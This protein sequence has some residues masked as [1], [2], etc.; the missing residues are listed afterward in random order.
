MNKLIQTLCVI[1]IIASL[2]YSAS[3]ALSFNDDFDRPDDIW[4]GNGWSSWGGNVSLRTGRLYAG[5]SSAGGCGIM[6]DDLP[7]PLNAPMTFDFDFAVMADNPGIWVIQINTTNPLMTNFDDEPRLLALMQHEGEGGVRR[8]VGA[9]LS[10]GWWHSSNARSWDDGETVHVSG[11]VFSDLSVEVAVDYLDG[12]PMAVY[13]IPG[14]GLNPTTIDQ[15]LLF[16]IGTNNGAGYFDNLVVTPE[17]ATLSLLAIGGLAMLRRRKRLRNKKPRTGTAS[18]ASISILITVCLLTA[19][20]TGS[21][22]VTF[23]TDEAAWL[24][25][26]ENV[27][28]LTTDASGIAMSN[29]ESAQP[30]VDEIIGEVL[31]F[32][33]SNTGLSWS[34]QL[35]TTQ[36]DYAFVFK[37][38][39]N[40]AIGQLSTY[41]NDDWEIDILGG[42][43]L[44]AFAFTLGRNDTNDDET[45]QVFD[46]TGQLLGSFSNVPIILSPGQ[47][48]MGV[49]SNE[50]IAHIFFDEDSG[51]DDIFIGDFRFATP[52]PATLSLLA[53]GGLAIIRR[54]KREMCK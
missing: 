21:A 10:D 38:N 44:R 26:V 5:S 30:A 11:T 20:S 29:E 40:L 18:V 24:A 6:R 42:P 17:P 4:I 3:A 47:V 19:C 27:Q 36:E 15:G 48:F 8:K 9:N 7:F 37:G 39:S 25:E 33:S 12:G 32:D 34:F 51:G 22:A 23:F 35:A 2:S 52:E 49:I 28:Q 46:G 13:T 45:F 1:A 31:T 14:P 43:D 50:P 16:S 41:D 54:R 53:L